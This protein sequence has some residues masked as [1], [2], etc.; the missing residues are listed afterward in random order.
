M[1]QKREFRFIDI[2]NSNFGHRH[3]FSRSVH[4]VRNQLLTLLDTLQTK[5]KVLPEKKMNIFEFSKFIISKFMDLGSSMHHGW[6]WREIGYI[7]NDTIMNPDN[8]SHTKVVFA[9][10]TFPSTA[11]TFLNT[12]PLPY[13]A[14]QLF[15]QV[16]P[17]F[18]KFEFSLPHHSAIQ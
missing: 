13:Q 6:S 16:C 3:G 17:A 4:K 7:R 5:E 1:N 8:E 10:R 12:L 11:R 9:F 18:L 15:F 14:Y 2:E